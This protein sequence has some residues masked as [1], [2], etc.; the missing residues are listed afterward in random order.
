MPPE[1]PRRPRRFLKILVIT[2]AVLVALLA[3]GWFQLVR[4]VGPSGSCRSPETGPLQAGTTSVRAVKSGSIDRCYRIHVPP[5]YSSDQPVPLVLSLHGFAEQAG[6]QEWLSQWDTLADA[7]NF[8][9]VYPEGLGMPLRW[10][11]AP[12]EAAK[13]T[14]DVQFMRDLLAEVSEKAS[15]DP[16]R[17]YVNGMSN[18]GAMTGRIACEMSDVVAAFG[19][20]SALPL[21]PPAGCLPTRAVPIIAFHGTADP[22]VLYEG[23]TTR[24]PGANPVTYPAVGKWIAGW[25]ARNGCQPEPEALPALA[26]DVSGV[27]Y[28]GCTDDV[29]VLFYTIAGGGHTWP[30]GSPIDLAGKTTTSISA[31]RMMWEFFSRYTLSGKISD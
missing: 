20:V 18:G 24:L 28:A 23:G 19:M 26:D 8:I 14:D 2:L 27:R 16:E 17:I 10:N 9:V 12:D 29:E 13:A 11:I 4:M 15:I 3:L 30:G 7:E 25:A 5:A 22:I 1:S 31:T 21:D 6:I